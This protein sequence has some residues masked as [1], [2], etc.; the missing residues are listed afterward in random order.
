MRNLLYEELTLM[1]R[2]KN[3]EKIKSHLANIMDFQYIPEHVTLH[4]YYNL[5][6]LFNSKDKRDL[7]MNKLNEERI[8]TRISFP[9]CHLQPYHKNLPYLKLDDLKN[10]ITSYETMLDIPAHQNL[11]DKEIEKMTNIIIKNV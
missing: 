5:T 10:T 4:P 8:E 11:T 6:C 7:I 1:R 9:P 3:V 2:K